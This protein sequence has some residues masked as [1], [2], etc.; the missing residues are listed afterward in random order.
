M[1]FDDDVATPLP[2]NTGAVPSFAR[3]AA[4][5]PA[6]PPPDLF[7]TG[8][9]PPPPSTFSIVRDPHRPLP[10]DLNEVWDT[11]Q[12]IPRIGQPDYMAS[13][14]A[15]VGQSSGESG[16]SPSTSQ[17]ETS[18]DK[19]RELPE[20]DGRRELRRK[21]LE[22]QGMDISSQEKARLRLQLLM[23]DSGSSWIMPASTDLPSSPPP[24]TSPTTT[25]GA[26]ESIKQQLVKARDAV[27]SPETVPVFRLTAQDLAPTYAPIPP[28]LHFGDATWTMEE[29]R[30]LGCQHY[31]RNVKL[32]CATCERWYTCRICHD[33]VEQHVLPRRLTKHMLCMV[34]GTAQKAGDTCTKCGQECA[35][36]YC[37]ICKFWSDDR[38]KKIYH[39]NDCG[40]CR[41]GQGIGKDFVHCKVSEG[42]LP[43][44]APMTRLGDG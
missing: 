31:Q 9:M 41:V 39:C 29:M 5:I 37:S 21:I 10:A 15:Q 34:C 4:S 12:S 17:S 30:P 8:A 38:H 23:K 16:S 13:R 36:Y 24:P 18:Q 19:S 3:N 1:H 22:V 35:H 20:N 27:M 42:D 32:Q 40:I 6:A 7:M 43:S 44:E 28:G 25:P 2:L 14:L 33:A 11:Q 26:L